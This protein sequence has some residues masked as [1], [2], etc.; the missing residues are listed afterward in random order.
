MK[1]RIKILIVVLPL[2]TASVVLVG[3]CSYLL[4]SSSVTRLAVDF[5]D[6]KA[7]ELENYAVGQ[8]NLLVDNNVTEELLMQ[9]AAKS[10]IEIFASSI[11]RSNTETIFMLSNDG[12]IDT[13]AGTVLPTNEERQAL[14]SYETKRGFIPSIYIAG[15]SRVAYTFP[16]SPFS[17]QVFITED[18]KTFYGTVEQIFR[19]S[20]YILAG[21]LLV[22]IAS[23]VFTS[24]YLTR[25]MEAMLR[26]MQTIIKSNNLNKRVPVFY[27][28]EIGHLSHTF[29][30]MLSEL[31][32]AYTQIKK[33]AFDAAIAQKQEMKIRNVFQ[34]YVPKDV[35]EEVFASPEKMLVGSN[36]NT[37]VLFSDIRSFTTI[38]ER[39]APDELVN[40]LNRYFSAMVNI[41]MDRNGIVDKYIG[42]AI[43]AIFGA[44]TSY[45][46]DALSSVL[47]GLEM[48]AALNDFNKLQLSLRAPEFKIGVG[49]SYGIVTVGNIGCNKKMNYTVIGDTVNLASRLEGLTK[50]YRQPVL[51]SESVWEKVHNDLPCRTVDKVAVKGKTLG[52][53]IFTAKLS[54][55]DTEKE[56][57]KYH[58]DATVYY[59]SQDFQ[60]ALTGFTKVLSILPGDSIADTF[61]KRCYIY[62]SEPPP[63][64]WDGVEIMH[65]K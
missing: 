20:A 22:G 33:Y 35:I 63:A 43:M 54:V 30:N 4:A 18:R 29:N 48:M 62:R 64:D 50:K 15:S 9:S 49:I 26:T 61:A 45:G 10:A 44:P 2:L 52:I 3:V 25:P 32:A 56:A 53:P 23:L 36:R 65:E 17:W 38:S 24:G 12:T 51:F 37:A 57:W 19:T 14:T 42:D 47:S 11:L 41:I 8:W 46:N 34:L 13:Y 1:I 55:T 16:F 21:A 27:Q 40:S 60:K 7:D 31:S 6:F 5:L 59:Y 39:M 58:E 28:D